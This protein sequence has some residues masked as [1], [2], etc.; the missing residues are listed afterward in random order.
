VKVLIAVASAVI[1]VFAGLVGAFLQAALWVTPWI[2]IPWGA[3][4]SLMI[5]TV[6][7][8]GACWWAEARWAG[9]LVFAGWLV[10]SVAMAVES[11]SG[12]VALGEGT[13]PLLYL[14]AAA[15]IGAFAATLPARRIRV[16]S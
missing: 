1:G 2:T 16:A 7:I 14:I 11:P 12:D 5:F 15:V 8:R 6:L 13:R 9:W 4:A 10:S 3:V